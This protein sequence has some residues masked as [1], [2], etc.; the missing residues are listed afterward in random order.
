MSDTIE[1][2]KIA[3]PDVPGGFI[4]INKGDLKPGDKIY[5]D[6][7]SGSSGDKPPTVDEIKAALPGASDDELL[8]MLIA[9]ENGKKRATAIDAIEAE[10]EA[11]RAASDN[12]SK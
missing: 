10:I 7:P 11:R 1:T 8:E 6:K 3:A 9:E 12:G 5:S 2:V 4:I